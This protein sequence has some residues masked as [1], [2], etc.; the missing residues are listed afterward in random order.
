MYN[1]IKQCACLLAAGESRRRPDRGIVLRFC[2]Y[3]C[4]Y[5]VQLLHFSLN[6]IFTE[7]ML[8]L[9]PI[10]RPVAAFLCVKFAYFQ[11]NE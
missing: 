8:F 1:M 6:I 3:F 7:R 2:G 10:F 9:M 4:S 11:C 5:F